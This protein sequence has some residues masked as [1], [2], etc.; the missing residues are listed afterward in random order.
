MAPNISEVERMASLTIGACL[1]GL[2]LR[3]TSWGALLLSALGGAL[4]Y[5]GVAGYCPLTD[6]IKAGSNIAGPDEGQIS[7]LDIVQEASEESFPASD[8]PGWTARGGR[9]SF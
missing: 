1:I 7:E 6:L 2:N 5:R 9:A 8:P 3:K 4:V